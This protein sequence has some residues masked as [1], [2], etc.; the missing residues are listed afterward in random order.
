MLYVCSGS[1]SCVNSRRLGPGVHAMGILASERQAVKLRQFGQCREVFLVTTTLSG[2]GRVRYEEAFFLPV[3]G[4][5]G[6]WTSSSPGASRWTSVPTGQMTHRKTGG[7]IGTTLVPTQL[8]G[9]A[10]T[11]RDP[12]EELNRRSERDI[13]SRNKCAK[14]K[15]RK[16]NRKRGRKPFWS[17]LPALRS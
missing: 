2:N 4:S 13:S 3:S 1:E 15:E 6:R 17:L 16:E 14:T 8:A 12:E 9:Q 10:R 5:P 7:V 11:R